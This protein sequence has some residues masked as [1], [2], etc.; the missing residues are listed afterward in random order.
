[1][2]RTYIADSLDIVIGRRLTPLGKR[3]FEEAGEVVTTRS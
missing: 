3:Q 1:L 2:D